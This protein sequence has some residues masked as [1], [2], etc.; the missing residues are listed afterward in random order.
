MPRTST[1]SVTVQVPEDQKQIPKKKAY[2]AE[3]AAELLSVGRS[4]I[5][6][7]LE[8]G[9]I[10]GKRV[11]GRVIISDAELERFANDPEEIQKKDP[12]A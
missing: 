6:R 7:L 12:A 3:E 1:K 10:H 11:Y 2:Y 4:L 9:K 5:Y 8:E